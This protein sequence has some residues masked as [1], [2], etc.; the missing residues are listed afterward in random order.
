MNQRRHY[1]EIQLEP[2]GNPS[3]ARTIKEDCTIGS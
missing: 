3:Q 1:K 2:I